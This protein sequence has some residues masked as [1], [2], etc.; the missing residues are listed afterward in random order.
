[1]LRRYIVAF[2]LCLLAAYATGPVWAQGVDITTVAG[3]DDLVADGADGPIVVPAGDYFIPHTGVDL[4]NG[5]PL[6]IAED[7]DLTLAAGVR[8]YTTNEFRQIFPS[9]I[10]ELTT[11]KVLSDGTTSDG[12]CFIR[13][14]GTLDAAA[15][16]VFERV[17]IVYETVNPA[18]PADG[19]I[20]SCTFIESPVGI[21]GSSPSLRDA[22][23]IVTSYDFEVNTPIFLDN[24][25]QNSN[26]DLTGVDIS[27]CTTQAIGVGNLLA[28]DSRS[29]E[30]D[31]YF[32]TAYT[33]QRYPSVFGNVTEYLL[34]GHVHILPQ[35]TLTLD[36]AGAE[37]IRVRSAQ[38]VDGL[39]NAIVVDGTLDADGIT[40]SHLGLF[41]QQ[42]SGGT[43]DRCSFIETPIVI[44]SGAPS[45]TNS[46]FQITEYVSEMNYPI[47]L[48]DLGQGTDGLV[49]LDNDFSA[50]AVHGI[51][52]SGR[53][54]S[55]ATLPVTV[56]SLDDVSLYV[57]ADEALVHPGVTLT[58]EPGVQIT[59][60]PADE[61]VEE[62]E[63]RGA[64]TAS[65]ATFNHVPITC[66]PGS[67]VTIDTG[68]V[69]NESPVTINAA[70]VTITDTAVNNSASYPFGLDH[71]GEGSSLTLTD[72]M[73]TSGTN[74]SI[75]TFGEVNGTATLPYVPSLSTYTL[76]EFYKGDKID[77]AVNFGGTLT[78]EPGVTLTTEVGS[79]AQILVYG[80]FIAEG[81]DVDTSGAVD[82]DEAISLL[83]VPLIF[84]PI[85][86]GSFEYA[87]LLGSPMHMSYSSPTFANCVFATQ[88][89]TSIT[90]G[91]SSTVAVTASD[92]IGIGAGIRNLDGTAVVDAIGCYWG[93]SDGPSGSGSGTGVAIFGVD[94][95][96]DG[97]VD[98]INV[99]PFAAAFIN[100]ELVD[101]DGDGELEVDA[102]GV[103][104]D[105]N[106]TDSDT[107]VDDDDEDEDGLPTLIEDVNNNGIV[108]PGETDPTNADTDN[109]GVVDGRDAFPLDQEEAFDTDSDG[110]G[111]N[112]DDDDDG[113]GVL[114]VFDAFPLDP[115]EDTDTDGDGI[116]DNSDGDIDGDDIPNEMDPNP[117]EPDL[118]SIDPS[119]ISTDI[120]EDRTLTTENSP[121][122]VFG[123]VNI[124]SEAVLTVQPD[125]V[126]QAFNAFGETSNTLL[127][128]AGELQ[129]DG[130]I[131][132]KLPITFGLA[133]S[134]SIVD[135][136]LIEST[137][138]IDQSSPTIT[139]N[140]FIV[141]S[142]SGVVVPPITLA[143]GGQAADPTISGNDFSGSTTQAIGTSG[144]VS[145]NSILAL[146]DDLSYVLMESLTVDAGATLTIG[147]GVHMMVA[148][149]GLEFVLAVNGTLAATSLGSPSTWF[150]HVPVVFAPLSSADIDGC[151]FTESPVTIQSADIR[152]EN[153]SMQVTETVSGVPYP[154][155]LADLGQGSTLTLA[156]NDFTASTLPGIG[157]GGTADSNATL[158]VTTP[159]LQDTSL[160][161]L[162]EDS[163]ISPG[164]TLTL[165]ST[166]DSSVELIDDP[167]NSSTERLTVYGTLN[168]GT[169]DDEPVVIRN[170]SL[171]F[172]PGSD[173]TL[174]NCMIIETPIDIEAASP[175]I[176]NC[177]IES[178]NM[179]PFILKNLGEGSSPTITNID[180]I[181]ESPRVIA[182][183][184]MVNGTATLPYIPGFSYALLKFDRGTQAQSVVR[185]GASLT[186]PDGVVLA[187][188]FDNSVLGTA[189]ADP[190]TDG[191]GTPDSR[192]IDDDNDGV[193]DGSDPLPLDPGTGLGDEAGRRGIVVEGMLIVDG[194]ALGRT[195]LFFEPLSS[196]TF[197]DSRLVGSRIELNYASALSISDSAIVP[198]GVIGITSTSRSSATVENC[199]IFPSGIGILN[200]DPTV[201]IDAEDNF[202]GDADG[203][204][205]DGPGLGTGVFGNVDFVPFIED[206]I[207]VALIDP[208]VDTDGDGL[209]DSIE[210]LNGN[211]L[212]DHG[213]TSFDKPDTDGDGTADGSD[214]FPLDETE[215]RDT[216]NDGVGD[217]TDN[218]DDDDGYLDN[219]DALPLDPTEW[220][221]TDGDGIGNNAD[222]DDDNDGILDADDPNPLV[223]DDVGGAEDDPS[224]LFGTITENRTLQPLP[225]DQPYTVMG[226]VRINSGVTLTLSPGVTVRTL[227]SF[228][229]TINRLVVANG[230]ELL[231]EDEV[232]FENVPIFFEMLSE[233]TIS[234]ST[235]RDSFVVL[236]NSSPT[237]TDNLF[238]FVSF[239]STVNVPVMMENV[240]EGSSPTISGNT[241]TRDA[242][243]AIG[244][245]GSTA[246]TVTLTRY[247][248]I[249]RYLLFE[250]VRVSPGGL[251][252]VEPDVTIGS[253]GEEVFD[254]LIEGALAAEGTGKASD[255]DLSDNVVFDGAPVV[256]MPV[257][258]GTLY[259]S[260]FI[261][262]PVIMNAASPSITNCFFALDAQGETT[263]ASFPIFMS[264][265]GQGCDP[266]VSGNEFSSAT[267]KLIG[268]GGTATTDALLVGTDDL[269]T[270]ALIEMGAVAR[271]ATLS[272][273][274][275]VQ[276]RG[277]E[278]AEDA[279]LVVNGALN[280]STAE[281]TSLPILFSP[282]SD[283]LVTGCTFYTSAITVDFASPVFTEC[284]FS[285]SG[286][287]Q[288]ITVENDGTPQINNSDFAGMMS[289]G[290][291][292]TNTRAMVNAEYNWWGAASGPSFAG[293]GSG[294]SVTVG[295]DYSPWL[296]EP[297]SSLLVDDFDND[298]I[299]DFYDDDDDNDGIPDA[300][301]TMPYDTDNDGLDND[302]DP[303]DD[304]DGTDDGD[305]IFPFD[306]DND[307]I[308]NGYDLDADNDGLS[309]EMEILFGTDILVA[310]TDDDGLTDLEEFLAGT[311]PEKTDSDGDGLADGLDA[312]PL[313]AD[314]D[315]D[316]LTD[317][318][319]VQIYGT[320]PSRA[321]SDGDGLGDY[322]ELFMYDTDPTA[323]DTDGGGDGDGTEVYRSTDPLDPADDSGE[324]ADGDGLTDLDELVLQTDPNDSDTDGDGLDDGLEV[325]PLGTDPLDADS[326]GDGL[327]DS[328]EVLELQTN[329]LDADTDDD[330]LTDLLEV[331]T[332]GSDPNLADTDG[333]G[334]EDGEEV[335]LRTSPV[336]RDTDGGGNDDGTEIAYGLD[337]LDPEDDFALDTDGDGLS[338]FDEFARGTDHENT[339]T[340]GDGLDDGQE[341]ELGSN[342][343]SR[344]T[345]GDGLTD[346]NEVRN[347]KTDPTEADT[348]GDGLTDG[349]EVLQY[350]T[351]PLLADTDGD[352][353]DDAEELV[354]GTNA[355]DTDTDNDG[356]TD[357]EEVAMGSD[358]F[359]PNDVPIPDPDIVLVIG[360]TECPL[361][362]TTEVPIS[363]ETGDVMP[364]S[365]R[366]DI[367]YDAD[368]VVPLDV[369]PGEAALAAG[370][371]PRLAVIEPGRV[372]MTVSAGHSPISDGLLAAVTF[373]VLPGQLEGT[374]VALVA[375]DR[376]AYSQDLAE[377]AMDVVS[378]SIE[379][380][381]DRADLDGSGTVDAIDIQ[382]AI[383]QVLGLGTGSSDAV[384]D[385]NA[386]GRVDATDLQM[387]INRALGLG[388]G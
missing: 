164:V 104:A 306:T 328:R 378:G 293:P 126:I 22:Q 15:G 162:T 40:F 372:R 258:T 186:I 49:I 24:F 347:T 351:D 159:V 110:I 168:A 59:T 43:L 237:I 278:G 292:S 191:D 177:A 4:T 184:G 5:Q 326:D 305:D 69:L 331:S 235:L 212:T 128:N 302:A 310:D 54:D 245:R 161:I 285:T 83:R 354:L 13:C 109:D 357:G 366:V 28:Y 211:G 134:G 66:S 277:M 117:Y 14:Q 248:D 206:F 32:D 272:V 151:T 116:G 342:P 358:P 304:N 99:D 189:G 365:L 31:C 154:I 56:S 240:G 139:G 370:S 362:L 249:S 323:R 334:I 269:S 45:I 17:P 142:S 388:L 260:V 138:T 121:Y 247:D 185:Y 125:V 166:V 273:G 67:V 276:I 294:V 345:D 242:T 115:S 261:D 113:D 172:G 209:P 241:F 106:L 336:L 281:F 187:A 282:F 286:S 201:Q 352:G 20:D 307:G 65:T 16:V 194:A 130:A 12:V 42:L 385:V 47:F 39:V 193:L 308:P 34:Q 157:T 158:P 280:A 119:I 267:Y 181:G 198:Q 25:G 297:N 111:N 255:S 256:F 33:A 156:D 222:N 23:F 254:L 312:A 295:V 324:D 36:S 246:E 196:G 341:V 301:D 204:S 169:S 350:V 7:G 73:F 76:V 77:T 61:I 316:G 387:L 374:V 6:F 386:D 48:T 85:S 283:G 349:E 68:S 364:V 108:D 226:Q 173:G 176:T 144:S 38:R 63:I 44:N 376:L 384:A 105:A 200:N 41:F 380:L 136:T 377:L 3:L 27:L 303:D 188:A 250:T 234:N 174:E 344:D 26:P 228:G 215:W 30:D 320:D 325:S 355:H 197:T 82:P 309:D 29:S 145:E 244:L 252:V 10:T 163:F 55:N 64:M 243:V 122:T 171:E 100:V 57:L 340:D 167:T 87:K 120:T 289:Y 72:N 60:D 275:G 264:N 238:D 89:I 348:D 368:V 127:V 203:P 88:G 199:D 313:A 46:F 268:T 319:E 288:A 284:I 236:N 101:F 11:S 219:E 321:D 271:G 339:D 205:G 182:T 84:T 383:N 98:N 227:N 373:R 74:R 81:T 251:L 259:Q 338:D 208:T 311:D 135:S 330:G 132:E 93:R 96:G 225:D 52:T 95:D 107:V 124:M 279:A 367:L 178:L 79:R 322:E 35:G 327:D 80:T 143:N 224:V 170:I 152:I 146:Y 2:V 360:E 92:F 265:L 346:A 155:Y 202:W 75:A 102:D 165:E 147:D 91:N 270:Y 314:G 37:T 299:V 114:D 153:C 50:S 239:G 190:D 220:L 51:G 97:A 21:L 150:D 90:A 317:G 149:G 214:P 233:G 133:G 363:I 361:L 333:D 179:L 175:V 207:N 183:Y 253:A 118:G 94:T 315:G 137:V 379:L 1:M 371:D 263:S 103:P 381:P 318:D 266:E 223:P 78:L 287:F 210:D 218:D 129:I 62:L 160:Y 71:L 19:T 343:L 356:A 335:V 262:S 141:T 332:V 382:K 353:L 229:D 213:E 257:S 290:V 232:T 192:D 230:G 221:D 231:A 329:P 337:P 298:Y 180:L 131:L 9:S 195:G 140:T 216:D 296:D 369:E 217:N 8:L 18:D 86:G 112:E 123:E 359:D 375:A 300:T 291:R 70:T 274:S 148:H 58:I 53:A